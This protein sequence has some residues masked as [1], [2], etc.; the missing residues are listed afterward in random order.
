MLHLKQ[1]FRKLTNKELQVDIKKQLAVINSSRDKQ[2]FNP[3]TDKKFRYDVQ[4][5]FNYS[6]KVGI[7]KFSKDYLS[8]ISREKHCILVLLTVGLLILDVEDMTFI[9]FVPLI[10]T[11]MRP[12][13]R[14][15]L[16]HS[17]AIDIYRPECMD[18]FETFIFKSK[19]DVQGW[20]T[21]IHK[22][23]QNKY[24]HQAELYH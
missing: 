23:Q 1:A 6:E 20:V 22:I 14:G 11:H 16:Q 3:M 21:S 13:A 15:K 12:T 5:M 8:L 19:L 17:Y 4:L 18:Q 2:L 24:E 7:A 9:N 10:G